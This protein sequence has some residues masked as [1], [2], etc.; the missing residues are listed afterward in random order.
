M[1]VCALYQIPELHLQIGQ[2]L[3]G[4]HHIKYLQPEIIKKKN[5]F[6]DSFLSFVRL[7]IC[8]L[9]YGSKIVPADR[10]HARGSNYHGNSRNLARDP[11]WYRHQFMCCTS[12]VYFFPYREQ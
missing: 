11:G 3:S 1:L 12:L 9:P 10:S 6:K 8:W 2:K 4:C 7:D 5:I